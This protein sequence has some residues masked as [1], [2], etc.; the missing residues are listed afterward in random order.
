MDYMNTES[1]TITDNL[2]WL[3]EQKGTKRIEFATDET[4]GDNPVEG[5]IVALNSDGKGVLWGTQ[6]V[7]DTYDQEA[8]GLLLSTGDF[9]AGALTLSVVTMGTVDLRRITAVVTGSDKNDAVA[10]LR[11][12]N[13]IVEECE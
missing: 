3:L 9:S 7:A 4:N 5:S 6:T 2:K 13:I 12:N 8:Y 1:L 10:D 11:K